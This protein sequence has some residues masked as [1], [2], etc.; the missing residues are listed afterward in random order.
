MGKK[1]D[2]ME[3]LFIPFKL[4]KKLKSKGFDE[5]CFGYY[6]NESKELIINYS[7]QESTHPEAKKRPTMFIV[8]NRNTVLPQWAIAAPIYQQVV[9]WFEA[10]H[11]IHLDR[12]WYLFR[13]TK[14]KKNKQMGEVT[15]KETSPLKE[16]IRDAIDSNIWLNQPK[17]KQTTWEDKPSIEGRGNA[18]NVIDAIVL[19]ALSDKEKEMIEFTIDFIRQGY[20]TP[21][22]EN[23]HKTYLKTQGK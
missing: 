23:I 3:K 19:K 22:F 8:D 6:D 7:N 4:A 21:N 12:I 5:P 2:I 13:T 17:G 18:V 20:L 9:D 11:N 10:K 16:N 14:F 1:V 15:G